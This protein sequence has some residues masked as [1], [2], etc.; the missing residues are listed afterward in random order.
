MS[1]EYSR[2]AARF[3]LT[4][5]RFFAFESYRSLQ[6]LA[7]LT[8]ESANL[9]FGLNLDSADAV[10]RVAVGLDVELIAEFCG[11]DFCDVEGFAVRELDFR[12]FR[13]CCA[14]E[15]TVGC[16]LTVEDYEEARS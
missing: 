3:H 4:L 2:P 10:L 8:G 13:Q 9:E 11:L 14:N 1:E 12:E 15:R 7:Y 16:T 6:V 5:C